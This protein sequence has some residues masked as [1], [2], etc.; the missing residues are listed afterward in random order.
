[1]NAHRI[2][3]G[4]E[5]DFW[6]NVYPTELTR[7]FKSD[8]KRFGKVLSVIKALEPVFAFIPVRVMLK[9][10]GFSQDFGDKMVYP[11]VALFFGARVVVRS[12]P[13]CTFA[14]ETL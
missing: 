2:S 12:T 5:G 6:T 3:F 14:H 13:K 8:I 9:M 1:M 10:F 4:K 7:Q 11:L